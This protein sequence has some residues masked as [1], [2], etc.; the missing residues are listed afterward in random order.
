MHD[1]SFPTVTNPSLYLDVEIPTVCLNHRLMMTSRALILRAYSQ[2]GSA[3]GIS[4]TMIKR[5]VY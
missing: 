1:G 3:I 2:C 4:L 5:R